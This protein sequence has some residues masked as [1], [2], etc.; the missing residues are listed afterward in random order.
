[1]ILARRGGGGREELKENWG[2]SMQMG[3]MEFGCTYPYLIVWGER[4][5]GT[6]D[7][8]LPNGF[9]GQVSAKV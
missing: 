6:K 7:S 8:F 2:F 9:V 4:E 5:N 3:A 1:M